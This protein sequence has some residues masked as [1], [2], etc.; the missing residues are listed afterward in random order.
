M[1]CY[2]LFL[3]IILLQ[4]LNAYDFVDFACNRGFILSTQVDTVG[5]FAKW[6]DYHP[7]MC[8]LDFSD[9]TFSQF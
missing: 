9:I 5:G 1:V 4:L 8:L 2:L 6:T 3:I 7:G